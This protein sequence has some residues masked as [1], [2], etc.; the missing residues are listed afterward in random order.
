VVNSKNQSPRRRP[1]PVSF[2]AES[3][4]TSVKLSESK[5]DNAIGSATTPRLETPTKSK[6]LKV[7]GPSVWLGVG[8]LCV[9]L[10][11]L[12]SFYLAAVG[13]CICIASLMV[14]RM[15]R[16]TRRLVSTARSSSG[17]E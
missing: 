13:L 2:Q 10:G 5:S 17:T 9:L 15:N 8:I 11:V 4:I 12:F 7:Y 1:G 16:T 3:R 14:V 6:D